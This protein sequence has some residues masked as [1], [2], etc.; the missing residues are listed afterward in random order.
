MKFLQKLQNLPEKNR[1]IILWLVVIFVGFG[2]FTFYIKN[3][4]KKLKNFEAGK[5]EKELKLPSLEGL[6][7]IEVP[8][9]EEAT[10]ET[11]Q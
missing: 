10:K 3:I 6:P 9:F 5:I 4:Q 7:K 1:K 11:N 2:L 8:D